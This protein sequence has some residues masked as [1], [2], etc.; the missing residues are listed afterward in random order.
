[1]KSVNLIM[2]IF[3]I[4]NIVF[5]ANTEKPDKLIK[6]KKRLNLSIGLTAGSGV[7]AGGCLIAGLIVKKQLT[8][9]RSEYDAAFASSD[10]GALGDKL[11]STAST[12]S[13]LLTGAESGILL[14]GA[15]GIYT[16]ANLIIYRSHKKSQVAIA[17]LMGKKCGGLALACRF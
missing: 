16:I 11:N 4:T 3:F 8:P 6:S 15:L 5:G 10:A 14:T 7:I 1:M 17:P 2:L 12:A 9:L 13:A